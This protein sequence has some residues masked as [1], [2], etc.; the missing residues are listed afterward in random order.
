MKKTLIALTVAAL[1]ST[2]ASAL[3][4][5]SQDG[6]TVDVTGAVKMV[7]QKETDK[8]AVINKKDTKLG[9]KA[10]YEFGTDAYALAAYEYSFL[11]PEVK[12]AYIGVGSASAGQLT[13]G[14]QNTFAD[15]VGESSFDNAFGVKDRFARGDADNMISYRYTGL[16]D[17]EFGVDYMLATNPSKKT[18]K[19][20][21]ADEEFVLENKAWFDL[22]AKYSANDLTVAFAYSQAN[23]IADYEY[24]DN[25]YIADSAKTFDVA[26][27]YTM[28]N[29]K[30]GLD[31]GYLKTKGLA[32]YEK[33][34][35]DL[36]FLGGAKDMKAYYV[37][38]GAKVSFGDAAVYGNYA[39]T[40]LKPAKGE[41]IKFHGLNLGAEY[42]L[43]KNALVF[44]EGNYVKVKEGSDSDS[45]K[46]IG[47]GMK[48]EW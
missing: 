47:V 15:G 40:V 39:Y 26:L 16:S 11:K 41:K 35:D 12:K 38:P 8:K 22:G 18:M 19:V 30:F 3:T 27:G 23:G 33:E 24:K 31:V 5:Y 10:K 34:G 36:M 45:V 44:I 6:A 28:D 4:V 32:F 2:S 9:V 37:S 20:N 14:L 21:G 29:V 43:A 17:W 42:T 48:V 46:A 1:A 7:L 13:F 25:K